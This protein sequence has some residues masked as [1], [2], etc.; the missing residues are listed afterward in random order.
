MTETVFHVSPRARWLHL[1]PDEPYT[2]PSLGTQGFIHCST[3]DQLG[4]TLAAHFSGIDRAHLVVLE[5][6]PGRLSAPLRWEPAP[7]AAEGRD[8]MFPH[9]YGPIDRVAIVS[10][11]PAPG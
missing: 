11:R 6:D 4:P 8:Q 3:A 10:S 9:V 2:D 7:G 5:I 1:G